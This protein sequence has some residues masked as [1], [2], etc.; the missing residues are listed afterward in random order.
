MKNKIKTVFLV[1]LLAFGLLFFI[2]TNCYAATSQSFT[3]DDGV[4][5]VQ[6]SYPYDKAF[7]SHV[8]DY[9]LLMQ[10]NSSGR[11][12]YISSDV[13]FGFYSTEIENTEDSNAVVKFSSMP[14]NFVFGWSDDIPTYDS[15]TNT[16][17]VP[18]LNL[19]IPTGID[20]ENLTYTKSCIDTAKYTIYYN[21]LT[22]LSG[23]ELFSQPPLTVLPQIVEETPLEEVMREV[24]AV[25][26]I[27]L[28]TIVGLISL[29]KGLRVLSTVLHRS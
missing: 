25:L 21:D 27:V 18:K 12:I 9:C 5:L 7:S 4:T 14:N 20:E 13:S 23:I 11:L 17:T 28:V 1:L 19:G 26:P 2:N 15:T 6:S 22:C 8:Y 29:R 24:I 16:Y 3:F 10:D